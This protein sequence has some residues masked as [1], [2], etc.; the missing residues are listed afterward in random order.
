[1]RTAQVFNVSWAMLILA[2][3]ASAQT[4]PVPA[5]PQT[6]SSV[7]TQAPKPEAVAEV[8]SSDTVLPDAPAAAFKPLTPHEKFRRW[9]H[10]TYSPYTFLSVGF[11]AGWAQAMGDWPTYGGGM[12][13]YGKRYGAT[14]ADTEAR[15]FF[16]SFLFPY[17]LH[18]DP[19]YFASTKDGIAPRV[20]YAVTR[21]VI[22]RDDEGD[23]AFNTSQLFAVLVSKSLS[24]A[25]YPRRDRGFPETMNRV[26]GAYVSDAATNV[27]REF[28]PDIRRIW[29][30]HAPAKVKEMEKN[31]TVEKIEKAATP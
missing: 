15:E 27:L 14:L 5:S 25:Y 23:R 18:Q 9:V 17:L 26:A 21:V 28:W 11:S 7:Q 24:N 3:L 2:V 1:M 4:Q 29:R 10:R 19:R 20:G 8:R 6:P 13:G 12:G 30:K 16:R 22:T 31:K